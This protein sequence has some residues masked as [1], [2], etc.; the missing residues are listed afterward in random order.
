[1][2]I[3][4]ECPEWEEKHTLATEFKDR[5][6]WI[7]VIQKELVGGEIVKGFDISQDL[8]KGTENIMLCLRRSHWLQNGGWL[9]G[10][11]E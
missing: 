5:S 11:Q 7:T 4:C 2:G 10:R 1:M 3:S 6:E 8:K 9:G